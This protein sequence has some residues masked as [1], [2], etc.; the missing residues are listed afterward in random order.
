MTGQRSAYLLL[1]G[2][3]PLYLDDHVAGYACTELDLGAPAV[4]DN[5]NN[6]PGG[7]GTD[8]DTAYHGSR[9]VAASITAWD[10]GTVPLDD[11]P[12]L[13]APYMVASARPELHY[14]LKSANTAERILALRPAAPSAPLANG[15][16]TEMQLQWVTV[17]SPFAKSATVKTATAYM[18]TAISPG[19]RFPLTFPLTFPAGS[20]PTTWADFA[21]AGDV[22]TPPKFRLY[23]PFSNVWVTVVPFPTLNYELSAAEVNIS[24]NVAAGDYIDVDMETRTATYF[25]GSTG[26]TTDVL[27]WLNWADT[28]WGPLA[29]GTS[30]RLEFPN[31]FQNQQNTSAISQVQLSWQERYLL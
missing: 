30:Y 12:G 16:M 3:S 22:P 19:F 25:Q 21:V 9:A 24:G 14:T 28:V 5:V 10:D 4:R 11:I 13:F 29:P 23:G 1:P 27:D 20:Y 18:G 7:D 2:R 17:G 31:L 6:T 15:A 8:D 26:A